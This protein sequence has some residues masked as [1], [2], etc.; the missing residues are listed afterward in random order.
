[1]LMGIFRSFKQVRPKSD[2]TSVVSDIIQ[3]NTEVRDSSTI[4]VTRV[5][6]SMSYAEKLD[7]PTSD[8]YSLENM[9][10]NG[11]IPREVPCSGLLNP[12]DESDPRVSSELSSMADELHS[13]D[14][15]FNLN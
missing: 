14:E 3:D 10:N 12:D 2:E 5:V 15:N 8:E 13:I 1:M 9:L 6:D 4:V 11:D 7:M